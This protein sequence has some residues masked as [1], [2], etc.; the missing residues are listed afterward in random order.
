MK[1]IIARLGFV[2]IGLLCLLAGG[3]G[4]GAWALFAQA[5]GGRAGEAKAKADAP[6]VVPKPISVKT[7]HPRRDKN[8]QMTVERPADV[9][10][11]YRA[12]LEAQV[13]G[14][15]KWI[16][17]AA[18]S[19]VE[20]DQVLV[21]IFVPDKWALVNEKKNIVTQRERELELAQEKKNAAEE[22][23]R[24]ALANVKLKDALIL[25][26]QAETRYRAVRF[27]NLETLLKRSAIE[28]I[29]RDEGEKALDAA[30]AAEDGARAAQ[31]KAVQEVEDARANVRV[32][33]AEVN[34]AKQL[35]E[36]AKSE[37]EQAEAIAEYAIVKAPFRGAVVRR[38]VDPGSFVQNA[39][40]GHPTP[41]LT[42]ERADIVTVVM[43]VPENYAPYV[44]P[45]TVA[46]LQLNSMPGLKIRGEVTRFAPSVATSAH[47]RTM[48]VE[49]DLWNDA[50]EKYQAFFADPKNLAE[51][52]EG[53]LPI[54]PQ[55]SGKDAASRPRLITGTFGTMTLIL[56]SFGGIE[57]IPSEA[58]IRSGGR[59]L[60]YVVR[61]GKAHQIPVEV[62]VDDGMLAHVTVLGVNGEAAGQLT[63][64][65]QVITSNLEELTEDHPV[66]SVLRADWTPTSSR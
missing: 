26:A 54:L 19:P 36:V 50:P 53:R 4:S 27:Q 34:R 46:V 12:S 60:I 14:E 45:G 59:A 21:R 22:M 7:V 20:K 40:T 41:I 43:N 30:R 32:L 15:V 42:L 3:I 63:E 8:F 35:I 23:V 52:K 65:D 24:T 38:H 48:R 6:A 5:Q 62:Q 25:E 28:Q 33:G 44:A 55:F 10:G 1:P 16:R 2:Q 39:T 61:D 56:K 31:F 29:A 17:V 58:V 18:G 51:L 37:S 9:E 64:G 66:T 49:V 13:A 47:D 11:Y 57:L